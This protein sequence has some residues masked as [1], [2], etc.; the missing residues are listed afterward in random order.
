MNKAY[1]HTFDNTLQLDNCIVKFSSKLKQWY[2]LDSGTHIEHKHFW[3]K[4]QPSQLPNHLFAFEGSF[5]FNK[6]KLN[7]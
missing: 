4:Q 5:Y 1:R 7:F 3:A 2:Y 6:Q